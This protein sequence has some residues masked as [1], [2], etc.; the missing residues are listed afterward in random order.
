MKVADD[1]PSNHRALLEP[2]EYPLHNPR[3]KHDTSQP[4][5][6]S[7]PYYDREW[8]PYIWY[9]QANTEYYYRY[10]GSMPEPPCFEGVHWRVVHRPLKV[11]PNQ[12]RELQ[13][14]LSNRLNPNTCERETWGT[15]KFPG[16]D[17]VLVNRPLQTQTKRHKLVYC[18]CEDWESKSLF[19]IN[20]CNQS[21]AE[22]GI[23][24]YTLRLGP[25]L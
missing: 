5:I 15:P 8:H 18:T 2:H 16:S 6:M 1:G 14:L 21:K 10:E 7:K 17:K 11:S 13:L 24:D 20:Y 4:Q 12:L 23:A 22:R 25:K 19:D 9:V 3:F